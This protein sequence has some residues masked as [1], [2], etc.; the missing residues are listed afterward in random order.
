MAPGDISLTRVVTEVSAVYNYIL[1]GDNPLSASLEGIPTIMALCGGG[2]LVDFR[3]FEFHKDL[4]ARGVAVIRDNIGVLVFNDNL[5]AM[6]CQFEDD[7]S[8][9]L[10]PRSRPAPEL[11]APFVAVTRTPTEDSR[12]AFIALPECHCHRPSSQ[13]IMNHFKRTLGFEYC[14][15]RVE[16]E[17]PRVGQAPKHGIIV[18]MSVEL[19]DQAMFEETAVFFRISGHDIWVQLYMP[20]L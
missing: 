1:H 11:M 19:R 18:F 8:L 3:F 7:V 12:M 6:M 15:E 9:S 2:R 5:N 20:L 16:V 14:I 10:I 13:D 17:R 4:V